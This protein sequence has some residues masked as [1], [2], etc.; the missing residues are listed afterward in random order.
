MNANHLVWLG[1]IL[2]G[3]MLVASGAPA[4]T[5]SN[6]SVAKNVANSADILPAGT[7]TRGLRSIV[8]VP[9]ASSAAFEARYAITG[10]A[11]NDSFA[12]A[13]TVNATA[14]YTFSWD[15]MAA[16]GEAYVLEVGSSFRGG[17]GVIDDNL[18]FGIDSAPAASVSDLDCAYAG[19]GTLVGDPLDGFASAASRNGTSSISGTDVGVGYA[20]GS[21]IHAVGT[22]SP[23][24]Y[25]IDCTFTAFAASGQGFFAADEAA[26]RFGASGMLSNAVMDDYPGPSGAPR[27]YQ[28]DDGHRLR[29]RV[30]VL[31][32]ET[33][34][35][36]GIDNDGDSLV[37]LDDLGCSWSGSILEDPKCN[38]GIDN[39]SDGK[40]DLVDPTCQGI[41]SS[42]REKP[43]GACGFFGIEA[44]LVLSAFARRR[45]RRVDV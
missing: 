22:G 18:G 17:L 3:G 25:T 35:N 10:I 14:D 15:V 21:E 11:D 29:V 44:M 36:D 37:D 7:S 23:Q 33:A 5:L 43:P 45:G 13:V 24:T 38:D 8:E 42:N 20:A 16:S 32:T 2:I 40:I 30:A 31:P 9:S 39:D 26:F 41:P 19:P 12:A 6:V 34:C 1:G 27:T 28:V 4:A